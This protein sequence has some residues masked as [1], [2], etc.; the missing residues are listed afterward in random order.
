MELILKPSHGIEKKVLG[1]LLTLVPKWDSDM[2]QWQQELFISTDSTCFT[3][4]KN[5]HGNILTSF[6]CLQGANFISYSAM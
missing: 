4:S 1:S 5:S 6:P 3:H 2:T